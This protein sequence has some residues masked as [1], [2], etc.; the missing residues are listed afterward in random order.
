M[1]AL[2]PIPIP[3]ARRWAAF[4]TE[5]LPSIVFALGVLGVAF[6]W[7]QSASA[8]TLIA[9]AEIVRT[10]VRAVQPGTL[11]SLDV[12]LLQPV[13]AGQVIGHVR[14]ATPEVTAATL[15]IIRA[16][17]ELLRSNL[18]PVLPAQRVAAG[19]GVDG[20]LGAGVA[21]AVGAAA[22]P[23]LSRRSNFAQPLPL[24]CTLVAEN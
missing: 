3:A 8:P 11:A 19:D 9:E 17:I 6:L 16:E 15:A 18:E 1:S 14:A 10:E 21:E 23:E 20:L 5:R 13:T 2:P 24:K 4:R 7:N 12:A 22:D